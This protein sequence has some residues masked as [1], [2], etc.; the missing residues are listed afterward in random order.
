VDWDIEVKLSNLKQMNI[1]YQEH[2]EILEKEN[3]EMK[4]EIIFL[5]KQLEYKSLGKPDSDGI[6]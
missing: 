1:I 2:I 5:K 3:D 6:E 4:S